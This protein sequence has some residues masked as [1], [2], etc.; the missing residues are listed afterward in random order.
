MLDGIMALWFLLTGLSLV[1]V[2]LDLL[3]NTPVSW[4]QKFAWILV[5]AYTGP[6]GLFLFLTTRSLEARRWRG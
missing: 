3:T 5:I 6:I 1:F 4:V 2:I